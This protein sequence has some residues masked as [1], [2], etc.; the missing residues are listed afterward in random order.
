M[1]EYGQGLGRIADLVRDN[2]RVRE[3][4]YTPR[5]STAEKQVAVEHALNGRLPQGLVRFLRTVIAR[6][7]QRLLSRL[8]E[9]YAALA[10]DHFD[11]VRLEVTVARAMSIEDEA[12]VAKS[13]SR[14]MGKEAILD[15]SVR[16]EIMGGI[17]VRV[18]ERVY[19]GSVR[20]Q[21]E[22][23]RMSLLAAAIPTAAPPIEKTGER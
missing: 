18:A 9:A 1:E 23:L 21:L 7:R 2:E 16:P 11:R 10:D 22:A 6:G 5:V 19:D 8:S 12:A 15:V 13:L 3:F 14:A 17:I 4:L 20:R